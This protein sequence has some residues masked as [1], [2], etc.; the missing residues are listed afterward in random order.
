MSH[1]GTTAQFDL[2]IVRLTNI[3]TTLELFLAP[4]PEPSAPSHA[5]PSPSAPSLAAPSHAAPSP[6]APS[7][8]AP[9]GTGGAK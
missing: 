7:H 1:G 3:L 4:S 2:D 9:S 5:A 8:A 6:S